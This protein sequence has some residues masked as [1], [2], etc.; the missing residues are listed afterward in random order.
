MAV[1]MGERV[2]QVLTSS[3]LD[4]LAG[5]N[6]FFKCEHLQKG[7]AF[8][9]RGALN[10]VLSLPEQ[11]AARGVVT[12]SSGNHAAAVAL[13]ARLRGIPAHIVVPRNAPACKI[14]AV[15]EYGGNL[16]LCDP[17]LAAREDMC[18]QVAAETGAT[19]IHP[20]NY[21]PVIAGQGTVGLELLQQVPELDVVVVPVSGGGLLS[22]VAIA[23]KSLKPQLKVLAAEPC[24]TNNAADAAASK[25]AGQLIQDMPKTST[26]ADGLQGKYARLGQHTWP[27]VRDLV[28][29]VLVVEEQQIISA[30]RLLFERMKLVVEPSGAAALAA[31]LSDRF[32]AA[33]KDASWTKAISISPDNAA[34]W[35]NRGT[36]RL[37]NGQWSAAYDDLLH[38]LQLEQQQAGTA[39]P[40][41][42][43]E[44]GN[45]E[46]ALGK[47]Q[48]ALDHYQAA[49]IDEEVG[50][51]A[52]ANYALAAFETGA[53]EVAVRSARQ[54]VRRD[55]QFLDMRAALTGFLW[56]TGQKAAA[57]EAWEELQAASDGWPP[58][59]TAALAAFL[60]L[61]SSGKAQGY[62]L[63][64]QTY[65]F[66]AAA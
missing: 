56:A 65:V 17:T 64:V 46:G 40:L 23:A 57:E 1:V 42:L 47:W 8:K 6:L 39:S 66:P 43:N 38:A 55:P 35:S 33:E 27:V 15:K 59:A 36:V 3:T 50:A 4:D 51:I 34:A 30:V 62:D 49:A 20:Y 11:L 41:L 21:E 31:V 45:A 18:T 26:V 24:G 53:D 25:A 7:G 13:A 44:L 9:F 10:S 22:G 58:R 29:G 12:H 60:N 14:N 16:F 52:A 5:C 37:Q 32:A 54:L 61:S 48:M 63:Q 19:F 2:I 28:D